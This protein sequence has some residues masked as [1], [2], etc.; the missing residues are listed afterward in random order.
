MRLRLIDAGA[1][2]L[3]WNFRRLEDLS[4]KSDVVV[5]FPM[6]FEHFSNRAEECV[7]VA[8]RTT[9]PR[10]RELLL[11]MARAWCGMARDTHAAGPGES[12]QQEKMP[13]RDAQH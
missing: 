13:H 1:R 4:L 12:S 6:L 3:A 8:Q 9:S 2:R 11:E 7:R 10:D 5:A